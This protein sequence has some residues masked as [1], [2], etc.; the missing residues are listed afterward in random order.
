MSIPTIERRDDIIYFL[1]NKAKS[2]EADAQDISYYPQD[3]EDKVVEQSEVKEHLQYVIDN[4]Y[5]KGNLS[6]QPAQSEDEA[7]LVVCK[8]A[9]LTD[10]GRKVLRTKYFMV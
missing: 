4:G 7:P 10:E 1:L 8:N 9:Q 5:L 2:T 3:F 6:E